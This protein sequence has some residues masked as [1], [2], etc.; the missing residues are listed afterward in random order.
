MM[1]LFFKTF[2]LLIF[3]EKRREEERKGNID[4]RETFINCL[5]YVPQPGTEPTTQACALTRN[6]NGY[7]S[8]CRTTPNQLNHTCQGYDEFIIDILK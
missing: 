5:S 4:V 8:L 3:R 6:Q 7:I 1:S 2:C